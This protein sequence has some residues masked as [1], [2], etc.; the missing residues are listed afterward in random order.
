M[1]DPT[2]YYDIEAEG[3]EDT[4]TV[5]GRINQ[6][7]PRIAI[8]GASTGVAAALS[9]AL[10]GKYTLSEVDYNQLEERALGHMMSE[11]RLTSE[12]LVMQEMEDIHKYQ[13]QMM[14]A[15]Q[16]DRFTRDPYGVWEM[17]SR[18]QGRKNARHGS[19]VAKDHRSAT[20][21]QRDARKKNRK[22]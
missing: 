6:A 11:G 12:E 18:G 22:K 2:A 10:A 13:V 16:L 3:F 1:S 15:E 14:E 19:R 9:V 17:R 7:K 21:R 5:T 4:G 8:I 20:K